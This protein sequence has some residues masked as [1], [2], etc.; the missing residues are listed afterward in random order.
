MTRFLQDILRQ[1]EE[2]KRAINH[3]TDTGNAKLQ[4]SVSAIR[5]A[6]Y[7]Y[8]TGIGASWNAAFA[9]ASI[10]YSGGHPVYLMDA[11]ELLSAVIPPGSVI[12]ALSRSGRSIEII[13]LLA[14]ARNAE[15][16]VIGVTNFEDGPLALES[17]IPVVIPVQSDFGISVNT[18]TL[19]ALTAA[20]IATSVVSSFDTGLVAKLNLGA[21]ELAARIPG[22]RQ[23]LTETSWLRPKARYYFLGR[24]SSLSSAY[25]TRLLWEEGVKSTATAMGTGSFR[26][27]P[28]EMVTA[29]THFGIWVDDGPSREQDMAIARD[30][31]KLGASVMLIGCG[32]NLIEGDLVFDLPRMPSG[33]QFLLD[34]VPAQLAAE[35]LAQRSGVNCDAFRFASYI[36]QDEGGI[37]L[38]APAVDEEGLTRL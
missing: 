38:K 17:G 18:Y 29:A 30:L 7:V 8:L 4:E 24:G 36:V 15:A 2:L 6:R 9:A 13:K 23:Q 12:L 33:W 16:T 10:F 25:E 37:F 35:V 31:R 5:T 20:A 26:H 14:K 21:N 19:L 32:L 1:S 34:I 28:Q 27:G 22:W 3:L 11:S